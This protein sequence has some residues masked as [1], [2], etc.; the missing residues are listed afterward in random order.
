METAAIA[1]TWSLFRRPRRITSHGMAIT[2]VMTTAPTPIGMTAVPTTATHAG[3]ATAM[4]CPTVT[5]AVHTT[6]IVA[7]RPS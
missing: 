2:T 4:A 6:H 3:T 5:T 1:L 7:E